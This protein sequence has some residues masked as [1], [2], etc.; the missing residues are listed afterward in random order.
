MDEKLLAEL[1]AD[2]RV[3][4]EGRS[5]ILRQAVADYLKRRRRAVIANRYR[6]AYAQEAGL[7]SDFTGWEKEGQWPN[8]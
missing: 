4:K 5:A 2:E 8:D 7:G 1:D 6:R 3:Q